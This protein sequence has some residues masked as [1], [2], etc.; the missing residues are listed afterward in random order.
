[1]IKYKKIIVIWIILGM[2][3]MTLEGIYRIREGGFVNIVMLPIGGL[4]GLIVGSINQIKKFYNMKIIY[5]SLIGA[6]CTLFIEYISGYIF[7][8]K[9]NLDIWD[10]S[11]LPLN[12]HGQ[13]CL[14]FG[15]IWFI[16]QPFAIWLEDYVRYI[17]WRE[18]VYYSLTQIYKDF[19]TVK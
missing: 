7:N 18:G 19:F 16:I 11:E 6:C 5:Q 4:C 2:I 9:L 15:V 14:L 13:V 1:M 12:I 17:L 3:Y 8:I 10:Y